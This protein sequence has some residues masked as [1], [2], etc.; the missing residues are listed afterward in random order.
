M[1]IVAYSNHREGAVLIYSTL[2]VLLYFWPKTNFKYNY[3]FN[4]LKQQKYGI[5]KKG[6]FFY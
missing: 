1:K 2:K 3:L 4:N 6:F 5:N